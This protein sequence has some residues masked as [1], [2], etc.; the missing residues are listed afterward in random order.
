LSSPV[1]GE[2]RHEAV[3]GGAGDRDQIVLISIE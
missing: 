1:E 2:P 3:T